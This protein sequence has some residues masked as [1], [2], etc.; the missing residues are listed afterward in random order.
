MCKSQDSQG[1]SCKFDKEMGE[2]AA[3]RA[4]RENAQPRS[5]L[6]LHTTACFAAH[7]MRKISPTEFQNLQQDC[8]ILA[9]LIS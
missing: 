1:R 5:K 2:Q 7:G 9:Y 4:G 6:L 8:R 3:S